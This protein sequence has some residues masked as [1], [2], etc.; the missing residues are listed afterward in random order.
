MARR[1]G[2]EGG[3]P[4]RR[5]RLARR[6]VHRDRVALRIEVRAG[7]SVRDPE[8][9]GAAPAPAP[10]PALEPVLLDVAAGEN[11]TPVVAEVGQD[12]ADVVAALARLAL[13]AGVVHG[14]RHGLVERVVVGLCPSGTAEA[15]ALPVRMEV[16]HHRRERGD[17]AVEREATAR[18]APAV[19]HPLDLAGSVTAVAGRPTRL[20]PER[21]EVVVRVLGLRVRG[22]RLRLID[23]AAAGH[24]KARSE[25]HT[26]ELQSLAYLVCRLLLEK[27]K[28]KDKR[29][30]T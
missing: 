21:R 23:P 22:G 14:E 11:T 24:T 27:K 7:G 9:A 12:D 17:G 20:E 3:V 1:Q 4:V 8:I 30:C 29:E 28:K 15:A 26:S 18:R 6:V 19:V 5:H 16:I 2:G 10:A 13:V 25:E